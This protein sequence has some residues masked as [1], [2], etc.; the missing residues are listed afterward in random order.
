MRYMYYIHMHITISFASRISENATSS[1][2]DSSIFSF[3]FLFFFFLRN[4]AVRFIVTDPFLLPN[5]ISSGPFL[6]FPPPP[7]L[8]LS[9]SLSLSIGI[10]IFSCIYHSTRTILYFF[11]LSHLQAARLISPSSASFDEHICIIYFVSD[12]SGSS[13]QAAIFDMALARS[14]S[15]PLREH[16]LRG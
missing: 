3:L 6:L 2:G 5:A 11:S 8:S 7:P 12:S 15:T 14:I 13:W 1:F 16:P 10:F 4:G 9:L